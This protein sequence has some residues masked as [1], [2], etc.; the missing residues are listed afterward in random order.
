MCS[1][2][3]SIIILKLDNNLFTFV[4][5]CLDASRLENC[6][7]VGRLVH[8]VC[9][10]VYLRDFK[11]ANTWLK[12]V[13]HLLHPIGNCDFLWTFCEIFVIKI[14]NNWWDHRA[15][16]VGPTVPKMNSVPKC[17]QNEKCAQMCP[18]WKVYHNYPKMKSVPQLPQNEKCTSI[19]PITPIIPNYLNYYKIKSV[20]Q[21]ASIWSK[22]TFSST[23]TFNAFQFA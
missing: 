13:T 4:I 17:A 7:K 18:K 15:R 3:L 23:A 12:C 14:V 1:N 21:C 11:L 9:L 16:K 10:L 8:G 19:T 2:Y 6:L 22:L 20:T 5:I